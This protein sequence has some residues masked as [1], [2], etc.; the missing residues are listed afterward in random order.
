MVAI[1]MDEEGVDVF[2]SGVIT[3]SRG[4][5]LCVSMEFH[6]STYAYYS[7]PYERQFDKTYK[8]TNSP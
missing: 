4:A 5:W 8:L 3:G 2:Y 7:P 1:E 6:H